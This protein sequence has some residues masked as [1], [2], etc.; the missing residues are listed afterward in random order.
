MDR[1][2]NISSP[3]LEQ[4]KA[5]YSIL[6]QKFSQQEV[7]NDRLIREA[8][9]QRV[10]GIN[11]ISL[12]SS[13]CGAFVILTAPLVFHY[14]PV[15]NASWTFVVATILMML[16]CIYFNWK[17]NRG[18][19]DADLVYCDLKEFATSVQYT[20]SKWKNWVKV[21]IPMII[22]WAGW[23]CAE[24]WM[25]SEEKRL[26]LFMICGLMF[27]GVIGGIIGLRMNRKVVSHCD[28]ILLQIDN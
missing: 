8:M 24:I 18:L 22:V 12:T 3:E 25:R 4:L 2:E 1:Y 19:N 15:V 14:N 7:L 20:R 13:L 23:L 6:K 9:M 26:A 5:E 10:R 17:Y 28:E 11:N 27:G 16:V 21:A